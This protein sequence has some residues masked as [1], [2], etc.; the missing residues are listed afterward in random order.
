MAFKIAGAFVE[1]VADL[2]RVRAQIG[3]LGGAPIDTV[4]IADTT[5]ARDELGRFV[6]QAKAP[7]ITDVDADTSAAKQAL[8]VFLGAV[9]AGAVLDI[10]GDPSGAKAALGD[11]ANAAGPAGAKAGGS[12]MG[13]IG[14]M[15][16]GGPWVAI[17]AAAGGLLVKGLVDSIGKENDS[18]LFSV[19]TGLDAATAARF[20][21]A[22][23]QAYAENFGDSYASNLDAA[24]QA[25]ANGILGGDATQVEIQNTIAQ[26]TTVGQVLGEDVAPTARAV[27][28]AIRTGLV[29]DAEAGFGL[30]IKAQQNGLAVSEDLLDTLNEYGTQFRKVGL[31]G[32]TALGL[33]SQAM[34]GG[35]RD[36]D[37]AADAIKEFSIRAVDGSELTA[38]A[39]ELLGFHAEDMTAKL[40]AGG[41]TAYD[42]L[43]EVL[44][45]VI[46]IEDP[47]AKNAA[48]IALFGTQWEDLG[49]A[50]N[51]LNLDTARTEFGDLNNVM[52]DSINTLG[53]TRGAS[54]ETAFRTLKSVAADVGDTFADRFLPPL[55]EAANWVSTHQGDFVGMFR[56]GAE[57]ATDFS[58]NTT[59]A[60]AGGIRST[61]EF[62]QQAG[63]Q[64]LTFGGVVADVTAD[65]AYAMGQR[66]RSTEIREGWAQFEAD[67]TTA[68][69]TVRESADRTATF[70][71]G[72]MVDRLRES[73]A[74]MLEAL[75]NTEA[76]A[77]FNDNMNA[78]SSA[79]A[80]IGVASD[81]T[82]V[83]VD[84]L[85]TAIDLTTTT[86]QALDAQLKSAK[87]SLDNQAASGH[88]AGVATLEL[89]A[90]HDLAVKSITDT[91]VSMGYSQ[92]AA[93]ELATQYGLVPTSIDTNFS[94]L[95]IGPTQQSIRVIEEAQAKVDRNPVVTFTSSGADTT[96]R[97]AWELGDAINAI[98]RKVT[99]TYEEIR[100]GNDRRQTG[101]AG[102]GPIY[103]NGPAGVDSVPILAA[104]GEFMLNKSTVDRIGAA[105]LSSVN[106]GGPWPGGGGTTNV[107]VT[108]D[109]STARTMREVGDLVD[110]VTRWD[111]AGGGRRG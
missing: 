97:S 9:A 90:A 33:V 108:I 68:L 32:P 51:G 12:M 16:K 75:D 2:T 3:G 61:G 57:A 56:D 49:A 13:G 83:Q 94:A 104:P 42:S 43:G 35:A 60:M 72:P 34:K 66:G 111:R 96:K 99:V 36:A 107:Y 30:L 5:R 46:A 55:V 38:E 18:A 23:G 65:M 11:V 101:R 63:G 84:G 10:K 88:A 69:G 76:T 106:S 62:V 71:E 59:I 27:G 40:A 80:G 6:A 41:Q 74:D 37:L 52:T 47:V 79:I 95:G 86:G 110:H 81:G 64:L 70:M 24:R 17:G 93:A 7:T 78:T 31:D 20:G 26:L 44:S 22:A 98:P 29:P 54:I 91:L 103:G 4:V 89:A 82:R 45:A 109:A 53:G 92:G 85:T 102:G 19:Q 28:Q 14:D 50:V 73:Q 8:A 58:I 48:G 39:F 100:A 77:R 105:T 15:L 1:V 25:F 67:A 87:A 21:K